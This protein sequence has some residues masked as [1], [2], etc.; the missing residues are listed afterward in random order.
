MSDDVAPR[1][2]KRSRKPKPTPDLSNVSFL[3]T[4]TDPANVLRA[5]LK[6]F[7]DL[8]ESVGLRRV[9]VITEYITEDGRELDISWSESPNE[10]FYVTQDSLL[11]MV[12]RT[13]AVI[14]ACNNED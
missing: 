6:S 7:D 5:K 1:R 11:S 3:E 2:P 4:A 13:T 12:S 8:P 14:A 10:P 9:L